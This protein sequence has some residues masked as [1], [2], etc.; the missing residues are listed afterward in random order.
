MTF[1]PP[2]VAAM[3]RAASKPTN[4]SNIAISAAGSSNCPTQSPKISGAVRMM[5]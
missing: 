5:A 4:P 1:G 2:I 3:G